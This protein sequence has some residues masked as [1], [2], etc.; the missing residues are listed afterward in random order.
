[1]LTFVF[2]SWK[3]TKQILYEYVQKPLVKYSVWSTCLTLHMSRF[4]PIFTM[5]ANMMKQHFMW[6]IDWL[7]K[8]DQYSD[9]FLPELLRKCYFHVRH[10]LSVQRAG[11]VPGQTTVFAFQ[12]IFLKTL[13]ELIDQEELS[14]NIFPD[15]YPPHFQDL[16]FK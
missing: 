11:K 15:I 5:K 8:L 3:T 14:R 12:T 6:F 16:C 2:Q 13:I 7:C 9:W 1:M 4:S 10:I